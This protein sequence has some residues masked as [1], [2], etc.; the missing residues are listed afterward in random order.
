MLRSN[1]YKYGAEL[2]FGLIH[3]GAVAAISSRSPPPGCSPARF[4][5]S[6]TNRQHRNLRG[7]RLRVLRRILRRL[8]APDESMLTA[9]IG[10]RNTSSPAPNSPASPVSSRVSPV[11]P[12]SRTST[13][14]TWARTTPAP[15][16]IGAS[17]SMPKSP[18]SPHSASTI[19]SS[20]PGTTTSLPRRRL[21]RT[22]HQRRPNA[23]SPRSAIRAH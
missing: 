19:A 13:P 14:Q 2:A 9:A 7:R 3:L 18:L 16:P 21:P 5:C 6:T 8:R 12:R 23:C 11:P 15:S 1:D 20:A 4:A 22:P 10:S 17:D